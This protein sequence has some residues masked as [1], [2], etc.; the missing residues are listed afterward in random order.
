MEGRAPSEVFGLRMKEDPMK[1]RSLGE[2]E[3]E[4][5]ES[6]LERDLE[7]TWVLSRSSDIA[8]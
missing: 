6:V 2:S 7:F 5:P 4:D 3:I 8:L 1:A